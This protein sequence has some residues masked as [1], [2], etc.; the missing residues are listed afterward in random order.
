VHHHGV[1]LAGTL[2]QLRELGAGRRPWPMPYPQDPVR[3]RVARFVADGMSKTAGETMD[4]AMVL[5]RRQRIATVAGSS[6][7]AAWSRSPPKSRLDILLKSP[8]LKAPDRAH[9][10]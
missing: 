10:G 3:N 2:Q 1:P 6:N 9:A 5:R 4:W 7:K 8:A